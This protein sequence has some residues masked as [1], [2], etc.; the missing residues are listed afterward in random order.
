MNLKEFAEMLNCREYR[1]EITKDEKKLAK[2]LGFV[3]VFGAF[4]D[5]AEFEGAIDDEVDCYDGGDIHLDENGL[6]EGCN[7]G[8]KYAQRAYK[9]CKVIKAIWGKEGFSWQYETDIPHETFD[10]LED[11]EKYCKGIVFDIKSLCEELR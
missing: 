11:G 6:F 3:V 2:E 5:L 9:K 10:I 4:D 7:C 8:C 1:N